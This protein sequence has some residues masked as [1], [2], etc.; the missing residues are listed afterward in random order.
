MPSRR[1]SVNVSVVAAVAVLMASCSNAPSTTQ[2]Q[3]AASRLSAAP[4]PDGATDVTDPP[5]G[6]LA[7]R[8]ETTNVFRYEACIDGSCPI[9]ILNFTPLRP[10]SLDAACAVLDHYVR[11]VGGRQVDE[12]PPEEVTGATSSSGPGST[13]Q[14][15]D[16]TSFKVEQAIKTGGAFEVGGEWG[17][18]VVYQLG[19]SVDA[20]GRWIEGSDV[21]LSLGIG[22]QFC[23]DSAIGVP[24]EG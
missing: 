12:C 23:S 2:V 13:E 15:Q 1:R 10:E 19:Y 7:E 5:T 8:I 11:S 9:L 3:T 24:C 16:T 6:A 20:N 18:V 17:N 4:R 22:H 21:E 14:Q